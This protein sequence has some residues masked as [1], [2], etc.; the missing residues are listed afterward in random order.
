[1]CIHQSIYVRY[2]LV[3]NI[4]FCVSYFWSI[5]GGFYSYFEI[6]SCVIFCITIV[7]FFSPR[8]ILNISSFIL[9]KNA[10]PEESTNITAYV[11]QHMHY[12]VT[13]RLI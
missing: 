9:S 10:R 6:L 8:I 7:I 12:M 3:L 2:N 1:M 11:V 5:F 13:Q 4:I